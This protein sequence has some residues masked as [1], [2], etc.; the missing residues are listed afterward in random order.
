MVLALVVAV[1]AYGT[2]LYFWAGSRLRTTEAFSDYPGRPEPGRGTNWLL[3]GS[4]SRASLTPEQREALHV[5]N[6][7]VLNT[8][9]IMVLHYGDHG[10]R[11]VSLPRDSYVQIPGHGKG[12]INSAY[13][14]GGAPLLTRTVEQAT[15]LRVDHYAEVDF[16]GFVDVVDALGG[17]SL[18]VPK[19]GLRDE[20]SGADFD[21]GCRRMDGVRALRYVRARYADPRGD[22]GRVERQRQLVSA[23]SAEAT[24]VSVLLPPWKLVPFL[25]TSLDAL[26][27]DRGTETGTLAHMG[28]EM[29]GLS[30]RP[31]GTTTVPVAGEP[32]IVGAGEVVVWDQVKAG[33]LFEALKNDA[34]I[35]A[36]G[37]G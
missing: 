33:R 5:G 15:G 16:L 1:A 18:C 12:K 28:L 32:E 35:P 30:G 7:E 6:D 26:T 14:A 29:K 11:L 27:L 24:G 10:P 9:T 25:S 31:G 2:G 3:V 13:A 37:S 17:V 36:S 34:P 20:R 23:V 8:D 4:D 22:L 19:G 21:G